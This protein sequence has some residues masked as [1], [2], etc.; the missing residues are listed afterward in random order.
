MRSHFRQLPAIALVAA[1]TAFLA[2]PTQAQMNTGASV[3][4]GFDVFWSA[5]S[6]QVNNP[7]SGT[8]AWVIDPGDQHPNWVEPPAGARW[9]TAEPGWEF[10][11]PDDIW[12][13]YFTNFNV[14]NGDAFS[15]AGNWSTDNNATMW[16]NGAQVDM[17]GFR[18]FESLT[19]FEIGSG[20]LSGENTLAV[21]VFNGSGSGNPSG[22]L[23][24]DLRVVPEPMSAAL[25]GFGLL[26]LGFAARTREREQ[27]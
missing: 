24:S 15:L 5:L 14:A 16:L 11:A 1:L 2:V 25:L 3:D 10:D 13:T 20:F 27:G 18:S 22:V 8:A 12:T 19:A 9:I 7:T 4:G 26:G 21:Q 17:T 6:G 23:V